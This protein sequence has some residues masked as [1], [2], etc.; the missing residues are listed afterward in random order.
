MSNRILAVSM[1]ILTTLSGVSACHD[2]GAPIAK[3]SASVESLA[4]R[5]TEQRNLDFEQPDTGLLV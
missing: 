5:F 1:A 4:S 3:V 2:V